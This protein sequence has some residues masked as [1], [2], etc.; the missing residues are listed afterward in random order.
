ML[1]FDKFI[2]ISTFFLRMILITISLFYIVYINVYD[3]ILF[4]PDIIIRCCIFIWSIY[5]SILIEIIDINIFKLN[6]L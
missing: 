3:I 6:M 4:M 2:L 1:Y 5:Y